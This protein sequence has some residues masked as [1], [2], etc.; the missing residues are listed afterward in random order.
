MSDEKIGA[1]EEAGKTGKRDTLMSSTSSAFRDVLS[2][3]S[4]ISW[5]EFTLA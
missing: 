2:M 1:E 5:V 3:S 4:T